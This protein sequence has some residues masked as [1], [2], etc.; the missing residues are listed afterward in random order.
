MS[1][2]KPT[3]QGRRYRRDCVLWAVFMASIALYFALALLLKPAGVANNASV[4]RVL[5]V[6]AT[7][8]V[9][10][11]IPAKHW[12]RVQADAVDSVFLRGLSYVVAL[13]LCE[14][15]ALS[16]LLL[17]LASGATHY[18]VFLLLGLLGMLLHFPRREQT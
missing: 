15:A 3:A 12:L 13:V 11:S 1:S 8:Y 16:G 6:L 2:G 5:M 9:L 4:E 7:S 10:L 17:R 14:A 18:Y